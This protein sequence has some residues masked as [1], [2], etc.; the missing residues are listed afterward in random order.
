VVDQ[1]V[2]D[3]YV[4]GILCD[5]PS[6][7]GARSCRDRDRLRE[8]ALRSMGWNLCR[9]WSTAWFQDPQREENKIVAALLQASKPTALTI[10][11]HQPVRAARN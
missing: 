1:N 6:Y 4:M 9:V 11:A 5:G 10:A 7:S 8:E 3:R 2:P